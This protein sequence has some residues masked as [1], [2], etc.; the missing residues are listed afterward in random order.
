MLELREKMREEIT[1]SNSRHSLAKLFGRALST[2]MN[3]NSWLLL[4]GACL[5]IDAHLS[6]AKNCCAD[7]YDL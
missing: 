7:K 4:E 3:K 6:R 2:K 5:T 1:C